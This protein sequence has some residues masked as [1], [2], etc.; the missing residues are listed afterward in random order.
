MSVKYISDIPEPGKV[1]EIAVKYEVNSSSE[2]ALLKRAHEGVEISAFFDLVAVSGLSN[3]ELASLLDLSFKTIQ[4]YQ[5]DDKKLNALNSEQLLKM[6][7]L[8]Q[9]AEEVF[10]DL[11]SF[12]RWLRKPA[13]GLGNHIPLSFM[14]T[15]GGIDLIQDELHRLEFGALA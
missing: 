7:V 1:Q 12:N 13:V 14:K 3:E 15:S 9:K 8:Y 10:G 4:R 11:A 5:K 6:I 2:Y